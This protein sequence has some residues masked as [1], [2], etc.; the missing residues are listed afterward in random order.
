MEP[1]PTYKPAPAPEPVVEV[2]VEPEPAEPE[3]ADE[4]EV[5]IIDKPLDSLNGAGVGQSCGFD[6]TAA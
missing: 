5:V 1:K 6:W 2:V 4:P 3:P